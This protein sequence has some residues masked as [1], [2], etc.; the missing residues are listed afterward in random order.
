MDRIA[1]LHSINTGNNLS[2]VDLVVKYIEP[3]MYLYSLVDDRDNVNVIDNSTDQISYQINNS[4][5]V[6]NI[7]NLDIY[8]DQYNN[9]SLYGSYLDI[10]HKKQSDRSL[11]ITIRKR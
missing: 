3:T 8:L 5:E 2:I 11:Y 7:N 10:T 1:F 9:T 6:N 4:Q